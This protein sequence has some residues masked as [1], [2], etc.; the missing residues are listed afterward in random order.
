MRLLRHQGLLRAVG[1]VQP[2][3]PTKSLALFVGIVIEREGLAG[4]GCLVAGCRA[5]HGDFAVML[6]TLGP[7]GVVA[8]VAIC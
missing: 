3:G 4:F 7:T 1:L 8:G 5:E 2:V 6:L